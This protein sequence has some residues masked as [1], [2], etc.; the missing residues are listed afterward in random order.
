M[1]VQLLAVW[2]NI[3]SAVIAI[4]S[5]IVS[6]ISQV[7]PT[8]PLVPLRRA[9][10]Y[11]LIASGFFALGLFFGRVSNTPATT[12][13]ITSPAPNDKIN[14][15][16]PTNQQIA[17]FDVAGSS[18]NVEPNS[19]VYVLIRATNP[20]ENWWVQDPATLD[21]SGHWHVTVYDDATKPGKTLD[22]MAVVASNLTSGAQISG[23][24]LSKIIIT[25]SNIVSITIASVEKIEP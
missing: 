9:A 4:I 18:A 6:V 1:D 16:L 8:G 2:S 10:L 21:A 12:I 13:A 14:V 20:I 15:Q 11:T 7:N 24:E 17:R 23:D 19:T 25:R 5:L 3:V 22:V